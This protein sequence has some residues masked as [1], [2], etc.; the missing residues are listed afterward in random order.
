MEDLAILISAKLNIGTSIKSINESIRA[1]GK[2][3]SLQKLNLK[4]DVDKSFINSINGFIEATKKLNIALEAQQ[5]VVKETITTTQKLDGSI[6]KVTTTQ[7]ANGDIIT[8]TNKKIKEENNAL[9]VQIKT[10]K[11]L[12]K[13]LNG[14]S[15]AKTKVNKN[16]FG[17]PTSYSNTYVNDNNPNDS[18]VVRT[19]RDGNVKNLSEINNYLKQ[20]QALLKQEEA[21][22]RDHYNALKT[23]KARIEAMDKLH[24]IALKQN[25]E[26]DLKRKQTQDKE[27]EALDRAHYMALKTEKARVEAIDKLHYLA[28][29]QNA[30]FD[31]KQKQLRDKEYE[32]LDR[33]HY[34]ALKT[35]QE[36]RE[37]M[38]KLHYLALQKNAEREKQYLNTVADTELKIA[39]IRR[40]Y[41]SDKSVKSGLLEIEGQLESL[42]KAGSVGDFKGRFAELNTQLKQVAVNAKTATSHTIS[43]GEAIRT[44]ATKFPIWVA[45]STAFYG[46]V[47]GIKDMITTIIEVDSQ[48]TQLK[49]VMDEDTNFDE[50]LRG[51]IKTANELGRSIK[52]VNEQL[53]G[54][55]RMGFNE[56]QTQY[57]ARTATL[58]QNISELTPEEAIDTMTAAMTVFN[59]KAED[60]IQ[61]ADKLNEVDNNFAVTSRDLA[62]SLNKAGASANTFGIS[63]ER[64]IGDTTAITTA[65][66]ESGSVVGNALKTI[67]SRLTT[68]DKS[69]EVLNAI[70][71]SMRD[72]SGEVKNGEVLIEE[73]ASKW[74]SL[75][76][77]Q[78]QNTAVQLA[79]RYQLTRFLAL[80]Q[81]YNISTAAT[82]T[83]LNSQGS[84][85]REN[86]K[87]M[88]S[89]EAKIQKMKTAWETFSLN[90][91]E[92][93][94]GD[95]IDIITTSL[96]SLTNAFSFAI[97]KFGAVPVIL[98]TVGTAVALLSKNFRNLTLSVITLG[99]GI[100]GLGFSATAAKVALRGL[101]ASTLVGAAFVALG[102]ALE[103]IMGLFGQAQ[104]SQEEYFENLKQ[105]IAD[106]KS[107]IQSL[108]KLSKQLQNNNLSQSELNSLYEQAANTTD[109]L[110]DHYTAEGDAVY[111]T[112]EQIDQ[113]IAAK[114]EQLLLDR[115]IALGN[116]SE[117]VSE[118]VKDISKN[119]SN[120]TK[121]TNA[122]NNL[123]AELEALNLIDDFISKNKLDQL[124]RTSAEFSEKIYELET[125]INNFLSG[126]GL[127]VSSTSYLQSF[128]NNLYSSVSN[129][130]LDSF[131]N[132]LDRKIKDIDIAI[133]KGK[134]TVNKSKEDL[135]KNLSEF[136]S[137]NMEKSGIEDKNIKIFNE[138]IAN[139]LLQAKKDTKYTGDQLREEF[140]HLT[141]DLTTYI[142]ENNVDITDLLNE[143]GIKKL[144]EKFPSYSKVFDEFVNQLNASVGSS[145]INIPIFDELGNQIGEAA[146]LADAASKGFINLKVNLDE[147]DAVVSF[148]GAI[149]NANSELNRLAT[150]TSEAKSEIAILNQ[151]Q[152]ELEDSNSLSIAT[153][154]ALN[155]KYED[156]IK[157]T[158]LSKEKVIE[159]LK[160]K[161]NEK[162]VF[163]NSEIEKTKN[164]IN[165]TKIRIGAMEQELS[166]MQKVRKAM[167]NERIEFLKNK[168]ANGEISDSEAERQIGGILGA[169]NGLVLDLSEEKRKLGE[170][171][172]QLNILNYAK[173]E[174]TAATAGDSDSKKKSKTEKSNKQYLDDTQAII[175]AINKEAVARE[176]LNESISNR[177]KELEDEKRYSDA[178]DK[179][180]TLLASQKKEV[181][182]LSA[183]NTKLQAE[184]SKLQKGSKYNMSTWL[185][186]NGEQSQTYIKLF[187]SSSE[188]TQKKLQELF[189]KYKLFTDAIAT[190]K[191]KISDSNSALKDTSKHLGDL[192]LTNTVTYLN[193]QRALLEDLNYDMEVSEK[194][195]AM[196]VE[197][198]KEYNDQ[199]LIQND[200]LGKKIA[201]YQKEIA[202]TKERLAQGN[203]TNDQIKELN[204]Y[205]KENTL[206]L[207]EAQKAA[208]SLAETYADDI[209]ENY[210][211]MIEQQRDLELDAIDERIDAENNRHKEYMDHLDQEQ[212]KFE[213]YINAQLKLLDRQNESDDYEYEL[214]KK[215]E[216]RQ[217]IVNE[218]NKYALDNS[219]EA[220]AKRK[221]LTDQLNVKDEEIERF[222][223]ERERTVRKEGLQDQLED[224]QKYNEKLKND[225][226]KLH[227]NT[228]D[229][230]EAEKK[231][232]QQKYKDILENEKYFYEMKQKLLSQDKTIV[233]SVLNELKSKYADFFEY[234]KRQTF[235]TSQAFENMYY[236]FEQDSNKL[237]NFPSS[238][239]NGS[240]NNTSG[241]NNSSPN[242]DTTNKDTPAAR[243]AW[244]TYLSNKKQ[245]EDIRKQ[246]EA[247]INKSSSQYK[248]LEKRFNFLKGQND[249]LRSQYSFF[250]DGS[251]ESLKN[252]N[253][254]S[255]DTGGMTPAWGSGGKFLLAHE[256]ELILNK[257]DTSNLIKVV[258]ITRGIVDSLKSFDLGKIINRQ[259]NSETTINKG[260]TIQNVN[261]YANDKDTGNSLLK[262]F[263]TALNNQ[264]KIGALKSGLN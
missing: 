182:L 189:D 123:S 36:K 203:L 51:S 256:K 181:E 250:P 146:N 195:Q 258:D 227:E 29:K 3:P 4:I 199:T 224:R 211:K 88:E 257:T 105:N 167:A 55:A 53:I 242:S 83:A 20:K 204:E 178:I 225:E 124:D 153:I 21:L 69:E 12:E 1:L 22:D 103:K 151:A 59:I 219:M 159:F 158:G 80:M 140:E 193:K 207:L 94:I 65:T 137:L 220:K 144:K 173:K 102:F 263:T 160:A 90:M 77:E 142:K 240:G 18:I 48:I 210:K 194:T 40:R 127:D 81:N 237:D 135:I 183:A 97:D 78:Q 24:Y 171:T 14:Y 260:V 118:S 114:K 41:G 52:D 190:N 230:L 44:A 133:K 161:E 253:P 232:T 233:D 35:N 16:K 200:I 66:R 248:D 252:F 87:Y 168:V 85:M 192:K 61:I 73:L 241:S 196:Y 32:A 143:N 170:L 113:L 23:E 28:L 249:A 26:F 147:N 107:S 91:G 71:I 47:R 205:L 128:M 174:L 108:E 184:R 112:K 254:F 10:L 236:K 95:S 213:D 134:D 162:I 150:Y 96:T 164:L 169:S 255:A 148:T 136:G 208:K 11:Q 31:L 39:D 226:D 42:K 234:L 214:N 243:A 82:E 54:F 92:K 68:M 131:K 191:E 100:K 221:E 63:M 138:Q 157:V 186:S 50:M 46:T 79:G 179:T 201:F 145:K 251:Y 7:L 129:N 185:D 8:Q 262:K 57:L 141:D 215:L 228:L 115:E 139:A 89:Y 13:E 246:M 121:K 155:E 15:L 86:A 238:G 149:A 6:E 34:M 235:E 17:E 154:Q 132:D 264:N 30:A 188:E 38:D 75:T 244:N 9:E 245:A 166:A 216:E 177:A 231:K 27:Y 175:N 156:F 56:Q 126:K 19:D 222:K 5:R 165:E 98:G 206:A 120:V 72:V 62:L 187:N 229:N 74:N 33:A 212:K 99:N 217:K 37:A 259:T 197:G 45:A 104:E 106:T 198:T 117:K 109:E 49:R 163:I 111:K 261:I 247:I 58:F 239:N 84:A 2:H 70:G 180:S 130:D 60:S 76:K 202:W 101:M 116:I 64:V 43:L 172:T 223:L 110:I 119:E 218:L 93:V 67:Y 122:R 25:A 125:L 209:I 152:K 176:K